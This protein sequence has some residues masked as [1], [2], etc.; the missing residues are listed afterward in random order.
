LAQKKGA[1]RTRDNTGRQGGMTGQTEPGMSREG[2]SSREAPGSNNAP[3]SVGGNQGKMTTAP[4]G[5]KDEYFS[6]PKK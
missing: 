3:Y 1:G 6:L 2:R 4:Q 5:K